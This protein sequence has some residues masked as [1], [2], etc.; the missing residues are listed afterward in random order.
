MWAY[1]YKDV[2]AAT[3]CVILIN[4]TGKA[5][6]KLSLSISSRFAVGEL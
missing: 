6:C 4:L 2:S 1:P 3:K 5:L